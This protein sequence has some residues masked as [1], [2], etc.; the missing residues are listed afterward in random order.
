M[1]VVLAGGGTAGH[2]EPALAIAAELE[3][4]QLATTSDIHFIGGFRGLEGRIVP[5]RGYQLHQINVI[6]LPRKLNF[7][8]ISYPWQFITAVFKLCILFNKIK[9]NFV[10]GFGG[11]VAAPSYAAAKLLRIPIVIHESNAR[12]GV[13]NQRAAKHAALVIE[14]FPNS[15]PNGKLLGTPIRHEIAVLDRSAHKQTARS[16]FS[17]PTNGTLILVFGGSQGAERINQ[18]ISDLAPKL[19]SQGIHV[20]HI[21]GDLNLSKYQGHA[22]EF[23]GKYVVLGYCDRMDL[24]YA[25]ADLAITRSGALTVAELACAGLPAILVPYPVGNGEQEFNAAELVAA[26]A[27]AL[28]RN[29]DCT[30]SKLSLLIDSLLADQSKLEQMGRNA[31]SI[32]RPTAAADIVAALRSVC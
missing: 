25:A 12:P 10:M 18:T 32:G 2:I 1:R 20:L 26:G 21:V 16:Y 3:R 5:A 11:Y 4:Q 9:P 8:L 15:L 23:A 17:M 13:T 24:A 7:Q 6:G 19:T 22:T 29:Q 28:L 27:A 30:E 31:K 14:S